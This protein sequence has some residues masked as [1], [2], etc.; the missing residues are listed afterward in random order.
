MRLKRKTGI[1]AGEQT[2]IKMKT[3][4]SKLFALIALG[5]LMA[6]GPIA[7]ADDAPA[8]T[9]PATPPPND[10]APAGRPNMREQMD[11]LFT[12]IK[13]T[14]DQKDKLKAIFKERNEK[15][16]AL[17]DDTGISQEDRTA[18]RKDITKDV[19]AKV[20]DVLSADQYEQYLKLQKEQGRRGRKGADQPAT[21]PPATTP[22]ADST[23]KN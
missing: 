13:A 5:G 11:K 7:R 21:T 6:V 4:K 16:K 18:K 23:P 19:N 12:A 1:E 2:E 8:Q 15:F 3:N 14:D 9:P 17:R 20:K 22:P 10:S